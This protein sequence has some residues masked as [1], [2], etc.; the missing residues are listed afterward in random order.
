M[1]KMRQSNLPYGVGIGQCID[2]TGFGLFAG[3]VGAF[4]HHELLAVMPDR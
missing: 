4:S 1:L 2:L 3:S